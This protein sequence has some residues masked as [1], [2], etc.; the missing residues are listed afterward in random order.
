MAWTCSTSSTLIG[1]VFTA[2]LPSRS[3]AGA[4]REPPLLT[5][6]ARSVRINHHRHSGVI[7]VSVAGRT[8]MGLLKNPP[9]SSFPHPENQ[10]PY[11]PTPP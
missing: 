1:L 3:V 10:P 6:L 11:P 4:V 9:R 2:P 7:A 5:P 8:Y